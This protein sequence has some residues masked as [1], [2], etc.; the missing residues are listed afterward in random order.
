[1][2]DTGKL[3]V[4]GLVRGKGPG[5]GRGET[6]GGMQVRVSGGRRRAGQCHSGGGAKGR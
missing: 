2:G 6:R 4:T 1:M 5:R 3:Q